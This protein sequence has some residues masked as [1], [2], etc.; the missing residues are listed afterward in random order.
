MRRHERRH[1]PVGKEHISGWELGAQASVAAK[2]GKAGTSF[3]GA[4][5]ISSGVCVYQLKETGLALELS[6]TG[7]KYHK[8]DELN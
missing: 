1:R 6:A 3:Q 4:L 8:D 2:A 7:T 5:P